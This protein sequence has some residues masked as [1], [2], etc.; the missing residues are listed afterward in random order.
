MLAETFHRGLTARLSYNYVSGRY[1]VYL[2]TSSQVL[3]ALTV[4]LTSPWLNLPDNRKSRWGNE[5]TAEKVKECRREVVA[6]VRLTSVQDGRLRCGIT[7]KG[8]N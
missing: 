3:L 8:R 4:L 7:T 1:A 6:L 2:A 5:L